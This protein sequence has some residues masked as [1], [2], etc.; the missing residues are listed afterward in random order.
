MKTAIVA[1]FTLAMALTSFTASAGETKTT[2]NMTQMSMASQDEG[3]A[4]MD[5]NMPMKMNESMPMMKKSMAKSTPFFNIY[6]GH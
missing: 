4:K 6:H 3:M 2:Q 5:E 1:A